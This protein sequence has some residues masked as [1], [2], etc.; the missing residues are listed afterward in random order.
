MAGNDSDE[1]GGHKRTRFPCLAT[2][3]YVVAAVVSVLTVVVVVMVIIVALRP[4]KVIFSITYQPIE[5]RPLWWDVLVQPITGRPVAGRATSA[6]NPNAGT[7]T[8]TT[9]VP[10]TNPSFGST[11]TTTYFAVK[12]VSFLVSLTADNPS[13]R[14]DV[15]GE[16]VTIRLL[17]MPDYGSSSFSFQR[18]TEIVT[19]EMQDHFSLNRQTSHTLWKWILVNNATVLS[20]LAD[21]YGGR[22]SFP[23]M[24]QV[25]ATMKGKPQIYYCWPVI[26]GRSSG[27]DSVDRST[28]CRLEKEMDSNVSYSG[29]PPAPVPAPAPAPTATFR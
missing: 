12:N 2:A 17:D 6:V 4:E 1:Y 24:V 15:S 22:T 10:V 9:T 5:A 7:A 29:P 3:R 11:E 25:N 20:Y 26:V 14:A 18:L 13:G 23:A 28:S 21:R 16:N 8:S 27:Y 19:Y